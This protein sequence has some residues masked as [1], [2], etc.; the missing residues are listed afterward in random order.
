MRWAQAAFTRALALS[1]SLPEAR[2]GQV[3]AAIGLGEP[4]RALHDV[5]PLLDA[6]PDGWL[7]AAQA[8]WLLGARGDARGLLQQA[9]A[10]G[11]HGLVARHRVVLARQLDEALAG[12]D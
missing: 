4:A 7:L 11:A 5:E 12:P 6:A 8:A 1:P 3:E 9:L 10:R 2:L